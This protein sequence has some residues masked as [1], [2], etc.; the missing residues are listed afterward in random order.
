MFDSFTFLL[1]ILFSCEYNLI[2]ILSHDDLSITIS[3]TLKILTGYGDSF[4]EIDSQ[5]ASP[6][7]CKN[8]AQLKF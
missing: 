1:S 6:S 4:E 3:Q 7:S 5:P 2:Y 8:A